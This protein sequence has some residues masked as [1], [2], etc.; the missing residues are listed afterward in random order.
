MQGTLPTACSYQ[1]GNK[2]SRG[3]AKSLLPCLS[4]PWTSWGPCH[5]MRGLQCGVRRRPDSPG[6]GTVR[7]PLVLEGPVGALS[8]VLGLVALLVLSV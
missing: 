1:M 3:L 2:D 6:S 5:A 7:A 4:H 8:S